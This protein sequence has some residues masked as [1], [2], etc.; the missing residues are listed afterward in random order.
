MCSAV[1]II[2]KPEPRKVEMLSEEEKMERQVEIGVISVTRNVAGLL[3]L[4]LCERTVNSAVND[5]DQSI[6][7]TLL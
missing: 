1:Q 4:Q 6:N 2:N 3:I 7:Q 5:T